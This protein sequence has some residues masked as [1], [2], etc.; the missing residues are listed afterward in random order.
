MNNQTNATANGSEVYQTDDL[1]I[2]RIREV[3]TSGELLAELP[4]TPAVTRTVAQTR[5]DIHNILQ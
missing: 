3:S 4:A 2:T 1:R 5:R